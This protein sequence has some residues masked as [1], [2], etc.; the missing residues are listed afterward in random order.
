[1][2]RVKRGTKAR[3]RRKRILNQAEG[4]YGRRKNAFTVAKPAVEHKWV[5][6]YVGRKQR[7]RNLRSL[8]IQ[9]I[10]AAARGLGVTYSKL[11]P[12]LEKAKIEIDRKM[13]AHLAV[14]DPEAFGQIVA[15]A[16][17]AG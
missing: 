12:M 11:V 2:A 7:K 14:T 10:N 5:Y 17:A 1:M 9:R 8:W 4:F 13:L 3:R 15:A 6:A 16:K